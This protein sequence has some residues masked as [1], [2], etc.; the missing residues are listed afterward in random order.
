MIGTVVMV[1][2]ILLLIGAFPKWPHSRAWGYFPSIWIGAV[3]LIVV[4]FR[5]M[6]QL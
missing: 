1:A 3:L 5:L 4:G 2:L 6:G